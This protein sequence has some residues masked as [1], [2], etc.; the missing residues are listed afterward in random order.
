QRPAY[1][2]RRTFDVTD[3]ATSAILTVTAHGVYEAFLNGERVGDFELTPGLTSYR[4][5]LQVQQYDVTALIVA[6]RNELVLVVS[7]GWFRGRVGA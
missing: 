6:G 2:F 1:E 3:T 5:T 7:D 4:K